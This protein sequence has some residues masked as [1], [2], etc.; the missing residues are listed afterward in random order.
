VPFYDRKKIIA[1]LDALPQM[2]EREQIATDPILTMAMCATV[3]Q[4][5][6]KLA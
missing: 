1:L 3:L 6:F 4:Q 5:H 2:S